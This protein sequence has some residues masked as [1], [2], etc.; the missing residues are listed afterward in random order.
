[1]RA[2]IK[3]DADTNIPTNVFQTITDKTSSSKIQNKK[4]S[5]Q[6]SLAAILF[7]TCLF[8]L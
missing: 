5:W 4:N 6:I 8:Q 7:M 3:K 2:I 1:M